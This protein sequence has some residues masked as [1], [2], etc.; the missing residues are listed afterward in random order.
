MTQS[1]IERATFRL[2][3]QCPDQLLHRVPP[4]PK[5]E[6]I[7]FRI[8]NSGITFKIHEFFCGDCIDADLFYNSATIITTFQKMR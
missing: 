4:R 2:V 6:G 5:L 8:T 7:L 3:V 1:G